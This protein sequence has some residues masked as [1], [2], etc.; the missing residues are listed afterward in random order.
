ML[1]LESVEAGYGQ[2]NCLHGISLEVNQGE[3]VV[4]LGANGAGKT[5]TL[6]TFQGWCRSDG[7]T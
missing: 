4:L 1:R 5:T 6:M 3:I 2:M 7:V